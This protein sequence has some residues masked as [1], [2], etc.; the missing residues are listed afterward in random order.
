MKPLAI[1]S[2]LLALFSPI[3]ARA[4]ARSH[5][6]AIAGV[7]LTTA[8]AALT[9]GGVVSMSY[10]AIVSP[11]PIYLAHSGTNCCGDA[12]NYPIIIG[13]AGLA[14]G[15]AALGS[16]IAL[17]VVGKRHEHASIALGAGA[18]HVRF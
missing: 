4:D 2:L 11:A 17:L 16:G 9:I 7:A 18:L 6:L 1:A 3:A 10:G 8:G 12:P 14:V 15:V 13:G 5:R